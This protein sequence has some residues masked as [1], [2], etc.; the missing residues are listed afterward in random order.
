MIWPIADNTINNYFTAHLNASWV[1]AAY[2][3]TILGS[4]SFLIVSSV[5]IGALLWLEKLPSRLLGLWFSLLGALGTSSLI[6]LLVARPRPIP[7]T[8]F[9]NSYSFPSTHAAVSTAFF[10]YLAYCLSHPVYRNKHKHWYVIIFIIL[11]L[12]VG[13]SRIYLG[14]HYFTDVLGGFLIGFIWFL[15]GILIQRRFDR[16][17]KHT[18]LHKQWRLAIALSVGML[19]FVLYLTQAFNLASLFNV[20]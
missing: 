15:F 18:P 17:D 13:F 5:S 11:P 20:E 10:L 9:E 12:L 14:V 4:G 19:I 2:L 6:K 8:Y 7:T 16:L 1:I 3:V